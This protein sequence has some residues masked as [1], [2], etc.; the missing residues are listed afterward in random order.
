MEIKLTDVEINEVSFLKRQLTEY[1]KKISGEV[2]FQELSNF[3]KSLL[4]RISSNVGFE[5]LSYDVDEQLLR[6]TISFLN[7]NKVVHKRV[8][9]EIRNVIDVS[10]FEKQLTELVDKCEPWRKTHTA[11]VDADTELKEKFNQ[12]GG[13]FF[14][15]QLEKVGSYCI[16]ALGLILFFGF[17]IQFL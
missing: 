10:D 9:F 4:T 12:M 1:L 6:G 7:D 5:M 3:S 17:L 11:W 2:D 16:Y 8:S 14:N 15:P 13:D